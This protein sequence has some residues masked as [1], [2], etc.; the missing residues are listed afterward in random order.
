MSEVQYVKTPYD[1][2]KTIVADNEQ[3]DSRQAL[4]NTR[5]L[6]SRLGVNIFED[7]YAILYQ[8]ALWC[9]KNDMPL[10]REVLQQ[11]ILNSREELVNSKKINISKEKQEDERFSD[12]VNYTMSEYDAM[13][14]EEYDY[15]N[16]KGEMNLFI[17]T[18]AE[19]QMQQ[20]IYDLNL[21]QH[22]GLRVG[23]KLY[24]GRDGVN[25]YYKRKYEMIDSLVNERKDYLAD[26]ID[27]LTMT[28]VEI[29]DKIYAEE[30]TSDYVSKFGIPSMDNELM[31]LTKGEIVVVQGGSGVG[32]SVGIHTLLETPTGP[33]M[34]KDVK[35][36]DLLFDRLGKPTLVQGVFPQGITER[37]KVTLSD[38]REMILSPDHLVPYITS[39]GNIANKELKYM[40]KNYLKTTNRGNKKH[41]YRIPQNKAVNYVKQE[42][43]INPYALGVLIGDGS[44]SEWDRLAVSF[45]EE[46][47][48]VKFMESAGLEAYTKNNYMYNFTIRDNKNSKKIR[49]AIIDLGLNVG[50]SSKFIPTS[51]KYDSKENRL[52]L[53][54]GLMD[55]DGHVSINGSGDS[56]TYLYD[57][58]SEKLAKDIQWIAQSLGYGVKICKYKR[59]S[60]GKGTEFRVKIYTGEVIVS[61]NKHLE[62]LSK[63]EYRSNRDKWVYITDIQQIE[64]G[65]TVCFSVDNPEHLFLMNDFIVTHNTRFA[66]GTIGYQ[67]LMMGKNV[68]HISLEQKPTRVYPMYQARHIVQQI[69]TR[70]RMSDSHI[71]KGTYDPA[72]EGIVQ[73]SFVDLAENPNYGKLKIVGR[74]LKSDNFEDYLNNIYDE[75]PFDVVIIDYFGLIGVHSPQ[76]RFAELAGFANTLKSACKYFKGQGFLAVV[77]NQLSTDVE[78]KLLKGDDRESKLGGAGSQDL[79]RGSDITVTLSETQDMESNGTIKLLVDKQRTG[80]RVPNLDMDVDKGRCIFVEKVDEDDDLL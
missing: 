49:E 76:S 39:K 74:D 66:I 7:E 30:T 55:T 50:S 78:A 18:W 53:L 32:K 1:L 27:T 38:G 72:D 4:A 31:G 57:T 33:V 21:I 65:E 23:N 44:L 63:L 61:S 13:S 35:V 71:F 43:V 47:V 16:L 73:E 56:Y 19:Q 69:G 11:L 45:S 60:E 68:L 75:F 52:E 25:Q 24:K 70:A 37:Y 59:E 41:V 2:F 6:V 28:G 46:D 12:I 10:T 22:E 48:L 58:V 67:A 62:R 5:T 40:V 14:E 29:K 42:H 54:K 51:Y 64:D 79:L 17:Q 20:L 77:P 26:D 80:S 3:Y 9:V 34:A 36:G 8:S 15:R